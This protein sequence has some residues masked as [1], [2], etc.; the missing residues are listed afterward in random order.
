MCS[1]HWFM[2]PPDIRREVWRC[3]KER[4]AG[5][6]GSA[7]HHEQIKKLAREAVAAKE[8]RQKPLW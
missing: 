6:D 1:R 7:E 4:Q 2:V 8:E 3:W 5:A